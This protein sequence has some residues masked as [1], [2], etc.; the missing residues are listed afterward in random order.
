M[1]NK[2]LKRGK[3]FMKWMISALRAVFVVNKLKCGG[4][5]K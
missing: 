5:E 1:K 2:T 4:E 3:S